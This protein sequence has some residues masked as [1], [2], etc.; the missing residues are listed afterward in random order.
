M[1][2][3]TIL[4]ALATNGAMASTQKPCADCKGKGTYR[5]VYYGGLADS[6]PLECP[7]CRGAGTVMRP[8]LYLPTGIR[9]DT[10]IAH[11]LRET[12]DRVVF[13]DRLMWGAMVDSDWPLSV[14][15]NV[16]IDEHLF[17][18]CE[19]QWAA[20]YLANLETALYAFERPIV[21]GGPELIAAALPRAS[22]LK[23][24][25]LSTESDGDVQFPWGPNATDSLFQDMRRMGH[26]DF[27]AYGAKFRCTY[28]NDDP[29]VV[30]STWTRVR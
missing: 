15:T 10:Y 24:C 18:R 25:F 27:T 7:W 3:L 1:K 28:V 5:E 21:L 20:T 9:N 6:G 2:D 30:Q 29:I 26:D 14:S 17:E 11:V 12:R 4:C 23:L 19:A 22:E 13:A 16:V 8:E